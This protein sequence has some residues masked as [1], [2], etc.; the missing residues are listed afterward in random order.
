MNT[1]ESSLLLADISISQEF[2]DQL[3]NTP[4]QEA[5]HTLVTEFVYFAYEYTDRTDLHYLNTVIDGTSTVRD[6]LYDLEQLLIFA[7][8]SCSNIVY[9]YALKEA[10]REFNTQRQ[11]NEH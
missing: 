5:F 9:Y 6:Y 11:V 8:Q 4:T 7:E 2:K 1:L 10:K 3:Q